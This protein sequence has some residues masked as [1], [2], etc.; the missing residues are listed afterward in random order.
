VLAAHFEDES[1][2]PSERRPDLQIPK[3]LDAVILRCLAKDASHR[4]QDMA[5]LEAALVEAQASAGLFTAWDDLPLPEVE[6]DR[7]A[8][9]LASMPEPEVEKPAS[10]R[11]WLAVGGSILFAATMGWGGYL[12]GARQAGTVQEKE[13]PIDVLARKA[14][15]AAAR[16]GYLV[17]RSDDEEVELADTHLRELE[18][19]KGAEGVRAHELAAELRTEMAAALVLT[20]DELWQAEVSRPVAVRY[21]G[22]ALMFGA[23]DAVTYARAT[24][25]RY[26]ELPEAMD[27]GGAEEESA[28]GEERGESGES[29]ESGERGESGE[30]GEREAAPER[31]A[32]E[33]LS[34]KERRAAWLAKAEERKTDREKARR[35]ADEGI[36]AKNRG[37]EREAEALLRRSLRYD[38]KNTWALAALSEILFLK[39][40]AKTA[41]VYAIRMVKLRPRNSRY[42]LRLGDI[43]AKMGLKDKALAEYRVAKE[44]GNKTAPQSIRALKAKG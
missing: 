43:Y 44:L 37:D 38:Y 15:A 30:G 40:D 36:A 4:Y 14:E 28:E 25:T 27:E 6:V 9:L 32:L 10:G 29:G 16:G 39:G 12:L 41:R 18:A 31:E 24:D 1:M 35:L 2:A 34:P 33:T 21:Y 11:R 19:M 17:P 13:D 3:A 26:Q 8:S 7:R 20:G 22:E 42:R 23:N 5:D